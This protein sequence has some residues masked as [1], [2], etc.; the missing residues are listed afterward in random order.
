MP[1]ILIIGLV[2]I[3]LVSAFSYYFFF[4]RKSPP[5]SSQVQTYIEP[6]TTTA[7]TS[8]FGQVSSLFDNLKKEVSG[9]T[10]QTSQTASSNPST[11]VLEQRIKVLE[12]TA[13]DLQAK[14][15]QLETG[16]SP[17]NPSSTPYPKQAPVYIPLGGGTSANST[18]WVGLDGYIVNINPADYPGYKSMQLEVNVRLIEAVGNANVRLYNQT[19]NSPISGSNV[20]TNSTS[21]TLLTSSGFSVSPVA[22]TYQL[23]V[24][25]T[26]GYEMDIQNARI[27]V[28]F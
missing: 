22:K 28:N 5:P 1:R 13:A 17:S 21:Y 24:Q 2:A 10:S 25:S 8:T 12:V 27:R 4:V 15:N 19:D 23:Q 18:A 14:V 6:V 20:S 3:V 26:T 11:D 7:P 16:T 9:G